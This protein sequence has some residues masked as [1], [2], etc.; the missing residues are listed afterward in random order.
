MT[1]TSRPDLPPVRRIVTGHTPEGKSIVVD[2]API[3]P[4]PFHGSSTFFTDVFWTDASPPSNE[5]IFRDLAKEHKDELYP[6]EGSSYKVVEAPP[7]QK[8]PLHRTLSFDYGILT[9]GTMTLILDDEKRVVMHPGDVIIQRGTIHAWHNEGTEW[10]RMHFIILRMPQ[11]PHISQFGI[12]TFVTKKASFLEHSSRLNPWINLV[13]LWTAIS[14]SLK[15]TKASPKEEIASLPVVLDN[16]AVSNLITFVKEIYCLGPFY[17][18]AVIALNALLVVC[19]ALETFFRGR[20]LDSIGWSLQNQKVE[21]AVVIQAMLGKLL[22]D[23]LDVYVTRMEEFYSKVLCERIKYHF[24]QRSMA[25]VSR[26][27]PSTAEDPS[28]YSKISER[29]EDLTHHRSD[30]AFVFIG[31]KDIMRDLI[32]ILTQAS[33]LLGMSRNSFTSLTSIAFCISYSLLSL[34]KGSVYS[35]SFVA[36]CNNSHFKRMAALKNLA[37]DDRYLEDRLSHGFEDHIVREFKKSRHSLGDVCTEDIQSQWMRSAPIAFEAL[38]EISWDSAL[39]FLVLKVL[40]DS[41]SLSMGEF[42]FIQ[43]ASHSMR[44]LS[45]GIFWG[46]TRIHR[47]LLIIQGLYS[48]DNIPSHLKDGDASYPPGSDEENQPGAQIEFRN[49]SFRYP[50]SDKNALREVSFTI[51][52]GQIVV[53]VG[54]N[55]SGKSSTIKLLNRLYDPSFGEIILDGL[56]LSSY[57][58]S[59]LRRSMAILRQNHPVFPLSIRENIALGSVDK[60]MSDDEV[61]Q[62]LRQ[63]GAEKFVRKLKQG[64]ETVLDPIKTVTIHTVG[65]EDPELKVVVDD[66][67]TKTDISGG[68]SQRLAASRTFSRLMNGNIRLLVVDEP[69]S[70]LDPEGEYELFT[71]LREHSKGK[72]AIFV[73]HRFGHLTKH[74][75][76]ILCLKDGCLVEQG[77]HDELLSLNGEYKKLYDVQARAFVSDSKLS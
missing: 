47:Q 21:T 2:D 48:L 71:K 44:G 77:N 56:P 69:T 23:V 5:V 53:I 19:T 74:A 14:G 65:A 39:V 12:W 11:K 28:V 64:L 22:L 55:G 60:D 3:E 13:R 9:H 70:A 33:V 58:L 45:W 51:R 29:S 42:L 67:E 50:G 37:F 26:L 27:D 66:M 20:I 38:L 43:Q 31:I 1:S 16:G 18:L 34:A 75:D 4:Y 54:V 52:P 41:K 72:T 6:L 24:L 25:F 73:T 61:Q 49:V 40:W 10:T 17:F 46:C 7:G 35:S 68:E 76:L 62:A 57:N 15:A 59:D 32:V 8:S 63:G 30:A 36:F